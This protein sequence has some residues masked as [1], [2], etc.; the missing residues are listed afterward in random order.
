MP[1]ATLNENDVALIGRSLHALAEGGC[2]KLHGRCSELTVLDPFLGIG[3]AAVAAQ[4]CGVA[5]FI[6]IELKSIWL[7]RTNVF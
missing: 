7:W 2:I 6:G 1:L 5:R 4:R 3:N